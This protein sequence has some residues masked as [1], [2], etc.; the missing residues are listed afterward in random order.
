[1]LLYCTVLISV[2]LSLFSKFLADSFLTHR[3][4]VIGD[5]MG[6]VRTENP[7]IAF[8]IRLPKSVQ[9]LAIAAALVLVAVLAVR[10]AKTRLQGIGFGLI[11]GGAIG[12]ILDRLPDSVVTDYFQ[13]GTFPVFNVADS[14]IT[15]GVL[16]LLWSTVWKSGQ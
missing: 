11:I 13:V 16:L 2:A 5:F 3:I 10:S 12:N 1:M 4:A 14:C 8:G 15:V 7:G 9:T 6:L